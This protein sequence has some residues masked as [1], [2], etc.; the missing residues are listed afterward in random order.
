MG[1]SQARRG[2]RGLQVKDVRTER[3]A[4]ARFYMTMARGVKFEN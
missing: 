1:Y 4:D 2:T 3:R